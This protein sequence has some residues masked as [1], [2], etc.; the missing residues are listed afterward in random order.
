[1]RALPLMRAR[2][3]FDSTGENS[4]RHRRRCSRPSARCSMCLT[5]TG[6]SPGRP[7]AVDS[8]SCATPMSGWRRWMTGSA[9]GCCRA[10]RPAPSRS[11]P[12]E[13]HRDRPGEPT[14]VAGVVAGGIAAQ[15]EPERQSSVPARLRHRLGLSRPVG[16]VGPWPS[17]G[18]VADGGSL[19]FV[20][21]RQRPIRCTP[22]LV[23]TLLGRF[24]ENGS[25]RRSSPGLG[26]VRDRQ[27]DHRGTVAGRDRSGGGARTV[28]LAAGAVIHRVGAGRRVSARPRP[29]GPGGRS[30][31][32]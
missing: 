12:D 2:P 19:S 22:D 28:L 6:P 5:V 26:G 3:W 15:L 14:R 20:A 10:Y 16:R 4:S 8:W 29:R 25:Q 17:A 27:G 21:A 30:A 9:V 11:S 7:T 24:V 31:L 23:G 32:A 13:Q 18:A 1:M